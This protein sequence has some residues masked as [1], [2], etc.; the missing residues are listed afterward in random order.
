MHLEDLE[1]SVDVKVINAKKVIKWSEW[2]SYN[3]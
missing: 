1:D 3:E 2:G